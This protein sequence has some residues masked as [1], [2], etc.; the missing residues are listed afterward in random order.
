[1]EQEYA[2]RGYQAVP[3]QLVK[4]QAESPFRKSD[5]TIRGE[6]DS[7]PVMEPEANGNFILNAF[8]GWRWRVG[9]QWATW[10]VEAPADG[11]F[12][13]AFKQGNWFQADF[14]AVRQLE[15]DGSVP[16][17]EME[18]V[19]FQYCRCWQLEPL[20]DD[21]GK[22]YLF[23]LTKGRHTIS[24][25]NRLG[26]GARRHSRHGRDLREISRIARQ[27]ILITGPNPDPN[28]DWELHKQIPDLLPRLIAMADRLGHEADRL[29]EWS[30]GRPAAAAAMRQAGA[31]FRSMTTKPRTIPQR[32][33]DFFR[34]QQTLGTMALSLQNT[35]MMLDYLTIHS[36]GH[37]MPR[38]NGPSRPEPG[39]PL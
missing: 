7:D 39:R 16:F 23:Y 30:D 1:M 35:P 3:E 27:V 17:R 31:Q 10:E 38:A 36:P 34:S 18:E 2:A 9:G 24:L 28:V 15:I 4:V 14:P 22:P 8:G 21:N 5:P 13:L 20:S 12:E 19:K 26:Q 11:L 33:E 29:Q 25:G 6:N 32:L 37:Q